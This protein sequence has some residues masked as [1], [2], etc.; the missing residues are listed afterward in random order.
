MIFGI[1]S[2]KAVLVEHKLFEDGTTHIENH[3]PAKVEFIKSPC[4]K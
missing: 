3:N 1:C 2:E 4:L